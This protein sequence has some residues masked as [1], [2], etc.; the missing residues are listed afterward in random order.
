MNN[1]STVKNYNNPPIIEAL[2]DI[3]IQ[4]SDDIQSDIFEDMYNKIKSDYPNKENI[5]LKTAQIDINK[6]Q[7]NFIGNEIGLKISSLDKKY[8]IQLK[9]TGLTFS[10]T[11]SYHGW[12]DLCERTKKLW[13]IFL[14]KIKPSKITRVAVRNINRIDIPAAHKFNLEEYFRVCPKTDDMDFLTFFLQIQVPQTEGGLGIIHQTVTTPIQAGYTSILL[15]LEVFDFQNLLPK[16]NNILWE[17]INTLRDQKNS[18]FEK[19]ITNKTREL[20]S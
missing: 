1:Q 3:Q 9:K 14:K 10:V 6:E 11:N 12:D 2:I 15:D 4:T 17:R 7:A 20:F 18:L 19:C 5:F 16:D 13:T 8:V